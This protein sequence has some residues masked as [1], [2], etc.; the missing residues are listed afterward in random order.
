MSDDGH[1]IEG[2]EEKEKEL[3]LSVPDVVTKYKAAADIANRA[4]AFVLSELKVGVKVVDVCAKGDEF[5][6]TELAS[7]FN[8]KTKTGD[9]V[10]KCIAFPTCISLNSCVC[11]FSPGGSDTTTVQ[12][13]DMAKIDLG[14]HIDGFIGV[15][16]H[17]VV[18]QSEDKPITGR[19]ADVMS[20]CNQAMEA[21]QRMVKPGMKASEVPAVLE[22]VALAYDVRVVEGVLS[23]QLKRFVIDG[24][25]LILSK[26]TPECKADE[27][28][29][30][31]N[32]VYSLDV[33]FST[34]EGKPKVMNEK[35]TTV[36]KRALDKEYHLKMKA[37]RFVFS[38]INKRFPTMPFTMRLIEDSGRTKLGLVE[39]LNHELLHPYPV[40]HEK[41]GDLVAHCKSTVL[42]MPNGIDRVTF[43]PAQAVE[44]TKKIEDEEVLKII[45]SSL[46]TK[47]KKKKNKKDKME[48]EQ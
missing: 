27:A 19:A 11:H 28:V 46:K 23:H 34:G 12:E 5:L 30:Q 2:E 31:E 45:S 8:K 22:K 9:K 17:T 1:D 10:E 42:V 24:N 13:G 36:Y 6:Q 48:V 21:V 26:P 43:A 3:D 32:E 29:F 47:T 40:L 25:K 4:L 16:A 38:E 44:T 41:P 33:C 18:V 15:V 37:S 20:A 14:C 35:E 7:A 39:C